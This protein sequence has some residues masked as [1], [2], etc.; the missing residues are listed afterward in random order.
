[1]IS[2]CPK[3][4]KDIEHED[5]LFEV[6]CEQAGCGTRFNP[7][8]LANTEAPAAPVA[9]PDIPSEGA[10]PSLMTEGD[11]AGAAAAASGFAES[12]EAF[13]EI[14]Q[15]GEALSETPIGAPPPPTTSPKA[16]AAK[17]ASGPVAP[18]EP[19]SECPITAGDTLPG[20]QIDGIFLP[21]SAWAEIDA[22]SASPFH[23]AFAGLWQQAQS[24]GASGVIGLR[25]TVSPD[26]GKV[27]A[28]GTPVRCLKQ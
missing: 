16:A 7:F 21:I 24:V 10:G 19:G 22:G 2:K 28:T 14:Q 6:R 4:G 13:Q 1:M 8:M 5:F 18:I 9:E 3:C 27:F 20:Y 12:Q 26:G 23:K 25:W 15:Y 11:A 17:K